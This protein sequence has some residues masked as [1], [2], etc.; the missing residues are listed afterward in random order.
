VLG[1]PL[2][3]EEEIVESD[4]PS[5]VRTKRFTMRPMSPEEA[6]DQ[7]ELLGHDFFVF[8]NADAQ[9]VNVLYRRRD[10]NYGCSSQTLTNRT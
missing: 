10:S 9:A 2:P 5:I 8:Y 6:V 3:L 1:E 4:Q 7:I